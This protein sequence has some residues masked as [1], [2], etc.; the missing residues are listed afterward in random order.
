MYEIENIW[1]SFAAAIQLSPL[2]SIGSLQKLNAYF[3]TLVAISN[4]NKQ[5]E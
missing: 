3:P 4:A 1:L 5:M 2:E